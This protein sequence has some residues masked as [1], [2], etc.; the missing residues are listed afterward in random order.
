MT[1]VEMADTDWYY[2]IGLVAFIQTYMTWMFA[3]QMRKHGRM[4][5]NVSQHSALRPRIR[6]F[7]NPG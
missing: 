2:A 4:K 7:H 6:N 5:P 3:R 1:W